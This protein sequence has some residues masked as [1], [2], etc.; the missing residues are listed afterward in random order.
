MPF[1][2]PAKVLVVLIVALVVLGADKLPKVAKQ[3][4][5]LSGDFRIFR[6]QLESDVRGSFPDL[7][8]AQ[9]ITQAVRSPL[10]FLDNLA[11][12]QGSENPPV[13]PSPGG[14]VPPSVQGDGDQP[15]S[16]GNTGVKPGL[17]AR[18]SAR[19]GP[20]LDP[21]PVAHKVKVVHDGAAD[22]PGLN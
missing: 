12:S 20:P 1:L 14:S 17:E 21:G 8:S 5:A 18:Q 9:T 22:D 16:G 3:I 6:Q 19:V 7:P 10:T 2:S 4:G 11:D 13:T 15:P